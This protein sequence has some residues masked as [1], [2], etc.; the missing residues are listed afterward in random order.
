MTKS[1]LFLRKSLVFWGVHTM[2]IFT[3]LFQKLHMFEVKLRR[4]KDSLLLCIL[5]LVTELTG[6]LPPPHGRKLHKCKT[7]SLWPIM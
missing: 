6:A 1:A 7:E 2:F 3:L 5:E 4:E